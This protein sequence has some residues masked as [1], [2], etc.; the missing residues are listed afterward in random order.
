MEIFPFLDYL[1]L[2][3]KYFNNI[4]ADIMMSVPHQTQK[5]LMQ[6][7]GTLADCGV[8]H[9]SCYSLIIEEGTPFYDM[10][11]KGELLLPSEEEDREMFS[12]L[13]AYLKE[14]GLERYEISNFA[15]SGF[16]SKH[17]LKYWKTM[18]YIGLGAG[19]HSCI[20]GKRFFNTADLKKYIEAPCK[21]EEVTNLS[22][23]DRMAEYSMMSLRTVDGVDFNE[24]KRRFGK[25]FREVYSKELAKFAKTDFVKITENGFSLT[26][27]GFDVS[28]AIMCEF[29]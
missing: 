14:K 6:T 16:R 1:E 5:S 26:E 12:K 20:D 17:N 11:E 27:K 19:A 25:D 8:Q 13:C 9:M 10:Y 2:S 7:I 28:N 21:P 18:D 29:V 4:N 24:F 22:D 15:K 3:K 23:A